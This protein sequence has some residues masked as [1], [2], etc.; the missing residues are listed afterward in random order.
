MRSVPL[1]GLLLLATA[2]AAQQGDTSRPASWPRFR[3][4]VNSDHSPDTGLLKKWPEDGPPR[5][6]LYSNAGNGYSGFSVADGKVYTMGTRDDNEVVLCLDFASG[7]EL[8]A[9]E[10]GP[11]YANDWGDGPRSTPTVDRELL[12]AMGGG[13]RLV[14]LDRKSG[15]KVW[16]TRMSKFGGQVPQW[17]YCESLLVDGNRVVCAP[18]GAKGAIVALDRGTGRKLWQATEFTGKAEY[19]SV[20]PAKIRGKSQYIRLLQRKL[21]AVDA[22]SGKLLWSCEWPGRTAVIPTPIVD[23]S[24]VY[25]TSGYG[26]GSMLVD[27]GSDEPKVVWQ[28]KVMKNH[29]GGVVKVGA[30]LY[31]HADVGWVC[32][33]WSDGKEVWREREKL[34]KGAIHYADGMLYCLEE[35]TGTVALVEATPEG[36]K[37]A[38]RFKLSPQS[39]IRAR[40][41]MIWVHPVVIG[42]HLLLRDQEHIYCFDVRGKAPEKPAKKV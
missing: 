4:A 22:G 37:E 12:F 27:V 20:V 15:K 26:V 24:Q 7:K 29:H 3:G 16:N 2:A 35:R 9:T 23:G 30:H 32:Q 41:G 28:N 36:Y 33:N 21:G 38:S 25:V 1:L 14:C 39:K 17:G 8:W 11:I 19:S 31:G 5:R 18:G 13:G 42:G 6:W 40:R 10:V 34:G